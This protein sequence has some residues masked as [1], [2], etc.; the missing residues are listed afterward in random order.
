M[1]LCSITLLLAVTLFAAASLRPAHAA[2]TPQGYGPAAMAA[3]DTP[4]VD[5]H[6]DTRVGVQLAVLGAAAVVVVVI[7]TGAYFLR[8]L[9]G[10]TA[11]PPVQPAG[12]H[13]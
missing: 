13:H 12:G 6:E 4:P 3:A 8:R 10:L 11:P 9:L 2:T 1:R 5:Q 7:G